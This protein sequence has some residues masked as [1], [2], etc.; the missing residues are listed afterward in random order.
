MYIDVSKSIQNGK[1]Y[2][3]YLLRES[4]R[5]NGK[6]KQRTVGN[7]SHCS[8]EEIEALRFALKHKNNITDILKKGKEI[9]SYQGLSIG[10]VS[11]LYRM[12]QDLGI[13]KALGNSEEA[14][15]SLWMILARLIEPGSRLANVR[16]AQRHAAIDTIG[17]ANF[18]EDD[19]YNAM[20][21]IEK[22]QTSIEKRLFKNRYGEKK[23]SLYLY[24]VTS[25][26]LEGEKNEYADFGYN[27]DKKRGK[28]QIVIGLLT[29]E[30][31]WPISIEVFKGNTNDVKTFSSQVKKLATDFVVAVM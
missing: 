25:S 6:V 17:M 3:R 1:T 19:L 4:Y 30:D 2:Y 14:K 7:I 10:A 15:R 18:N 28:K 12:A 27:R 29:D 26:Y 20:D 11:S 21:W 13:V 8:Q 5:E 31:G 24:D 9:H 22:N 16:L 23:P